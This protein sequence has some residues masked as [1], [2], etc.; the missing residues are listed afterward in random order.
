MYDA[1][2]QKLAKA[3][4]PY[5]PSGFFWQFLISIGVA[6]KD[7][8]DAILLDDYATNGDPDLDKMIGVRFYGTIG[9][10][11]YKD[12]R[13]NEIKTVVKLTKQWPE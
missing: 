8:N 9:E 7:G 5:D 3:K 10:E 13:T 2:P 4:R 6:I 11:Q 12:R 1:S